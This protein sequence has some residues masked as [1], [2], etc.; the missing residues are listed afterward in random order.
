MSSTN[1]SAEAENTSENAAVNESGIDAMATQSTEGLPYI[2]RSY[3]KVVGELVEGKGYGKCTAC[4]QQL[5]G[6]VKVTSNLS[7]HMVNI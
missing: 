6:D 4:K 2:L 1:S 3:F 5:A 7:R